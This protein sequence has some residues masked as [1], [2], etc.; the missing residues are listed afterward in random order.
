MKELDA[1][2]GTRGNIA[3]GEKQV[4]VG[5]ILHDIEPEADLMIAGQIAEIELGIGLQPEKGI[6]AAGAADIINAEFAA[7]A[8]NFEGAIR[9]QPLFRRHQDR[10]S[11]RL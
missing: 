11:T 8:L 4:A 1:D 9:C 7:I 10:K 6:V 3:P 5:D 2:L